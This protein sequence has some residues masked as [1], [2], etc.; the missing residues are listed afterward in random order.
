MVL[1]GNKIDL[2]REVLTDEGK[3]VAEFHNIPFFETSAKTEIGVQECFQRLIKD[4]ITDFHKGEEG[5]K[6][7]LQSETQDKGCGC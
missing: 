6:L 2:S 7:N 4:V 1:V 3:K 5:I